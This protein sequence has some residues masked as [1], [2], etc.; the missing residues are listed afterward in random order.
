MPPMKFVLNFET[1]GLFWLLLLL[2]KKVRSF[3][4]SHFCAFKLHEEN[5]NNEMMIGLEVGMKGQ[6]KCEST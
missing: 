5:W 3:I 6:M 4:F 1:N 2:T